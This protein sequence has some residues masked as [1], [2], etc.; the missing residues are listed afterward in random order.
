VS[1]R[2]SDPEIIL[3]PAALVVGI[4]DRTSNARET[5]RSGI[6]AKQWERFI[7]E[8]LVAQI[9]ERIDSAVVGVYTEYASDQDGEYTFVIGARVRAGAEAPA[10]M[11][12]KIVPAGRY[13]VFVSEPG[14]VGEVV[15]KTWQRVWVA[16]IDRAYG[17]DYEVYDER[18]LDP[19]NA[20][21]EVRVGVK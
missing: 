8:N 6:I 18:A 17:A 19:A 9:P 13:A 2:V 11:V 15:M 4:A 1:N 20:V 21:V 16:G 3:L 5:A 14:P 7:Q 10:G 12:A